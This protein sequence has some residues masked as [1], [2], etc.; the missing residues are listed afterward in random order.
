MRQSCLLAVTWRFVRR[1][2]RNMQTCQEAFPTS[3]SSDYISYSSRNGS[4]G[5]C[6]RPS[7]LQPITRNDHQLYLR[8]FRSSTETA[9]Y[10]NSWTYITQACRG[11]GL[12]WKYY[13]SDRLFS[14][15]SHRGHY[16]VVNPLGMLDW[17]MQNLLEILHGLSGKPVF[18]K[19]VSKASA[20]A[21]AKMGAFPASP[22]GLSWDADAYGDDDTYPE[23][24]VAP[25][26]ALGYNRKPSEWLEH[27]RSIRR[28][29]GEAE[30]SIRA[31]YRQFRR[32]VHRISESHNPCEVLEYRPEMWEEIRLFVASY[33]GAARPEAPEAYDNLMAGL[34]RGIRPESE[35]CFVIRTTDGQGIHGIVFAERLDFSSAGIYARLIH[36][37]HQ[38]LPEYAMA[39]VLS[40][41]RQR[42]IVRVNLGGSETGGLH[43]F[44]R[45][46]APVEERALP[47]LVYGHS[48]VR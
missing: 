25:D 45:K 34:R 42:G 18:I 21:L 19:K 22:E 6:T 28:G 47:L 48:R 17:R 26:V 30:G 16:V 10:A 23:L 27:Y 40:L 9:V 46:L 38:G 32:S 31:A 5:S 13:D 1:A 20:A 7:I 24:I 11:L 39:Q 36:R 37:R 8:F 12:G 3:S 33:F 41:L 4:S 29:S 15:G 35:L 44:K 14:V 43:A 2:E